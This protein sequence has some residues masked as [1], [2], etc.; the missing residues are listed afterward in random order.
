MVAL[1]AQVSQTVEAIY[2]AR[3][4]AQ[5]AGYRDHLGYSMIGN[6][7][8]RAIWYSFRWATRARHTGRLLRLFE[9]GHLA[10]ERLVG[11]LRRIG[12]TVL[13]L[14]PE[15]GRQWRVV[16]PT[17]HDGGSMDA[18][19]I[20]VPEAPKTWHVCE[21]KT[22]SLKSFN[23]LKAKGVEQSKPL[24]YAQMQSYMHVAGLERALYLAVCKDNDE[25]YSE[26]IHYDAALGPKLL[27]KA[28]RIVN[29]ARPPARIAEKPDAFACKW[30]DHR[31]V[32]WEGARPERHCRSCLHS[33]PVE[34]GTWHCAA[35]DEKRD[36]K[37]QRAG[38]SAH[39]FLPDFIAGEQVDAGED[40]VLYVLPDGTEWKDGAS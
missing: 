38:C 22:H 32:C 37:A 35:R 10:E 15:T 31:A 34:G 1:P 16:G 30:C 28:Q 39:L 19:A 23:A 18:V 33:T 2:A 8:S 40:W 9:T 26:R 4:V 3:E 36:S 13:D 24:H 20:G 7:C 25:L 6:E 5:D 21:F 17:S 27:A 11:D 14:D 29:A 12:V